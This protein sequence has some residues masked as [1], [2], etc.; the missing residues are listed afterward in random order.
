MAGVTIDIAPEKSFTLLSNEFIDNH[1]PKANPAFVLIYIYLLRNQGSGIDTENM[2]EIFSM[3]ESDIIKAFKY[4]DKEG[5]IKYSQNQ[6]GSMGISFDTAKKKASA[7]AKAAISIQNEITSK[8]PKYN[9]IELEMYKSDYAEIGDLFEF[10]EQ[11]LGKMLS[12][13]EL[14]TLYGFYDWLMMPVDLIKYLLE[15]C[16]GNGHRRMKYIETVAIDWVENNIKTIDA[17]EGHLNLFNKDY[18]DILK[19]LGQSGRNPAPK[20][21]EFMNKWIKTWQMPI[22]LIV[23]ACGMTMLKAGKAQFS[24]TDKIIEGWFNAGAKT[25]DDVKKLESE[26]K[27]KSKTEK[28]N[29]PVKEMPKRKNRFINYEQHVRDYDEIEK[30]ELE[31][32]LNKLKGGSHE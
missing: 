12:D 3:L 23:E 5:L 8:P 26:F 17:A 29:A 15:Y 19:A 11:T 10:A 14:S 22:E 30:S 2:G 13:T 6:D 7:K 20:E 18:R 28:E 27:D 25:L 24:Y 32:L 21:I 1:M 9:P 16:A 4:W 31:H